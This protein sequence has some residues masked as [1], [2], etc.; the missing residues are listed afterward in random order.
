MKENC[1]LF[2]AA[3]LCRKRKV[4]SAYITL[5][6]P[7]F[8]KGFR[9]PTLP[10]HQLTDFHCPGER[11]A[12]DLRPIIKTKMKNTLLLGLVSI[13]A[14]CSFGGLHS[15]TYIEPGQTFV[16]GE[17][18]HSAFKAKAENI[19]QQP[20]EI[21]LKPQGKAEVTLGILKPGDQA[22]YP[23]AANTTVRLKNLGQGKAEIKL[24]IKGDTDLGMEYEKQ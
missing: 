23:V 14:L 19:G 20:V 18:Q 2:L 3:P 8:T 15:V 5:G 13:L 12:Q 24:H 21:F 9:S 11:T 4:D 1:T 10:I 16:L 17:G 6:T 22:R 7:P